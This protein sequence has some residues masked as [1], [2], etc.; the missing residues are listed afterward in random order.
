M[1]T[2]SVV[3]PGAAGWR[4]RSRPGSWGSP[5]KQSSRRPAAP[6]PTPVQRR[7]CAGGVR[8]VRWRVSGI[9]CTVVS[10]Q[11]LTTDASAR[12][13]TRL[14]TE[15]RQAEIVAAALGPGARRQ[16]G[17]DHHQ[18]HRRGRRRDAGRG[19]QAL[20]DQGRDLAG[21]DGVGARA[22]AGRA[23][24]GRRR[25]RRHRWRALEAVF[26]AHVA[27]VASHP[28]VPRLIFHEL[29]QPADSAVKQEVR[30]L[31]QAYRKLLMGLLGAA[32][33]AGPGAGR[34]GPGSRGDAVRRHRPGPG[35]AVDA[36]RQ[37]R[38]R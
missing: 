3:Q 1:R 21:G 18:R 33:A 29:Q 27:F 15:E 17:A 38:D 22:I 11:I 5:L 9:S 36:E 26:K 14:P 25:T 10:I 7:P 13:Q 30:T 37:A 2:A 16:P 6:R 35:H 20:P 4:R 23:D 31:L 24:A 12:M 28:G 34:S 19:V 32:A 8:S